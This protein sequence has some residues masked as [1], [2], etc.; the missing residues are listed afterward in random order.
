MVNPKKSARKVWFVADTKPEDFSGEIG[1][2]LKE[3]IENPLN[4][5]KKEKRQ[6]LGRLHKESTRQGYVLFE[7]YSHN[8]GISRVGDSYIYDVP[9]TKTGNLRPFRNQKIRVICVQSGKNWRRAYLA[10]PI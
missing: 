6:I 3:Y 8:F 10:G 1:K 7:G 4:K 5:M 2:T 9:A